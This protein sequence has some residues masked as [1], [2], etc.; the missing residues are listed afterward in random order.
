M[1]NRSHKQLSAT[2][3]YILIHTVFWCGYAISWSYTAVYLK[4][5]GYNSLVVGL[6]T[7]GGAAISVIIQPILAKAI[8]K[9]SRLSTKLNIIIVKMITLVAAFIMCF[10]LPYKGVVPI[11]FTILTA[12]DASIPSMLNS[13]SME[14]MN[15]GKHLNYGLA[16]GSGSIAY[17]AFSLVMGYWVTRIGA[18]C[19]MPFYIGVSLI[20]MVAVLLFPYTKAEHK[21]EDHY[22]REGTK[23]HLLKKYP[24]LPYF[25]IASIL[26]FM[27][28]NMLSVFLL[29]IIEK[30]GGTS[31]NLG[32]ALAISATVELPV[33]ALFIYM[34]KW[35]KVSKLLIISAAMFTLKALGTLLAGG[36]TVLYG[37]QLMQLGAFAIFIPASVY[38]INEALQPEDRALGQALLGAATLG[39]GG[40]FG[41]LLG[42]WL[43]QKSGTEGMIVATILLSAIAFIMMY[44]GMKCYTQPGHHS[45]LCHKMESE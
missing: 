3:I 27:G 43:L 5:Q 18:S 14:Y 2:F 10:K 7:G 22:I 15:S 20:N 9:N 12:S 1:N 31:S 35:I 37:V 17:A 39:L 32:T 8:E 36:I 26:L 45:S 41:N 24:F 13:L 34:T 28:H 38:F 33:M 44:V 6:V 11:L 40:T 23:Y 42:G 25:L 29:N 19:L 4:A 16:R 21:A 30:V